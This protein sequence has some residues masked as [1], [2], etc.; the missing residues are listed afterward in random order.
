MKQ[1]YFFF[2]FFLLVSCKL[3][4]RDISI[5]D[6]ISDDILYEA[7]DDALFL[8]VYDFIEGHRNQLDEL[9]PS[10]RVY[11]RD[12]NYGRICSFI[13][14]IQDTIKKAECEIEWHAKFD[15]KLEEIKKQADIYSTYDDKYREE[16]NYGMSGIKRFKNDYFDKFTAFP[17]MKLNPYAGIDMP[18]EK[19]IFKFYGVPDEYLEG[20]TYADCFSEERILKNMDSDFDY[21]DYYWM[22][23]VDR[24]VFAI[25]Q[26][27][28]DLYIDIYLIR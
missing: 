25:Y 19:A 5:L 16:Y 4:Y 26:Y 15:S 18:T 2:F 28:D 9:A 1:L 12:V 20:N 27:L 8:S 6:T 21:F 14:G 23:Q 7:K 24:D 22:K 17:E 10:A 11:Y 13:E 3:S